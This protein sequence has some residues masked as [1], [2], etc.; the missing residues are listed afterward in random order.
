MQ[1]RLRRLGDMRMRRPI[2]GK[3][4]G[5]EASLNIAKGLVL[6][7]LL[8]AV[9]ILGRHGIGFSRALNDVVVRALLWDC[10][11][12]VRNGEELCL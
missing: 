2:A 5:S 1:E 7:I 3:R 12:T 8:V 11:G 10:R 6:I 9:A 4:C